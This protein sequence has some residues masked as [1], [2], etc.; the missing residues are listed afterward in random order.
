MTSA[1][2]LA[3]PLLTPPNDLRA[4]KLE[5]VR[6]VGDDAEPCAAAAAARC[7]PTFAMTRDREMRGLRATS[8]FGFGGSTAGRGIL[9]GELSSTLE[10]SAEAAA[11]RDGW[12]AG[13]AGDPGLPKFVKGWL[14]ILS[15]DGDIGDIRLPPIGDLEA[16]G[17]DDCF[18]ETD[19][20]PDVRPDTEGLIAV[21]TFARELA[22]GASSDEVLL[23]TAG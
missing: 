15:E 17:I 3:R 16:L 9:D 14:N 20:K 11:P 2:A 10:K 13:D 5:R 23:R 8:A 18:S 22:V 4:P 12:Y 19:G 6:P 1:P 7:A 21:F